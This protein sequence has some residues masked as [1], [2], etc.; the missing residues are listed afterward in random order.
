MC[1]DEAF[2]KEVHIGLLIDLVA[3]DE[4]GNDFASIELDAREIREVV[5]SVALAFKTRGID[6]VKVGKLVEHTAG[7]IADAVGEVIP[8]IMKRL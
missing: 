7:G 3:L 8:H 6:A 2:L 5:Q 4:L 1:P